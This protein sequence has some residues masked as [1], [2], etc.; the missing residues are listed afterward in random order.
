VAANHTHQTALE[1]YRDRAKVYDLELAA[2][3]PIRRNAIARLNLA[4][5]DAVIDVG[6]GTGL[7]F[8]HLQQAIGPSGHIIGIEQ[9]P[10]ML[11]HACARVTQGGW[12][13]VTLL[14]A[15]AEDAA[16]PITANAA[17]FHFTH[18]ILRN[19]AAIRNVMGRLKPGAHVV[20]VGLQW[21]A[22]WAWPTN[23]FVWLAALRSVTCMEGLDRPWSLLAEAVGKME[24]STTLFGAIYIASGTTTRPDQ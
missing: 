7:S 24:V 14:N 11:A 19:D 22:P 5:G 15:S 23:G 8:A 6:C 1:Q 12:A 9:S 20:A 3:E 21:A 13:N 16:I 10:E 17:L 4:P 2:F 18:D